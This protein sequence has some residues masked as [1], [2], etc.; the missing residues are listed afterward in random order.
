MKDKRDISTKISKHS[1]RA[2]PL[3]V[4]ILLWVGMVIIAYVILSITI[5]ILILYF[6]FG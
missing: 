2:I 1:K 6:P 4:N 3:T 5:D